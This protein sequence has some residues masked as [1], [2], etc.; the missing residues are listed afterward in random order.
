[1]RPGTSLIWTLRDS[2]IR[3]ACGRRFRRHVKRTIPHMAALRDRGNA[4]VLAILL[5][6]TFYRP[7]LVRWL[8][9]LIWMTTSLARGTRETISVGPAQL[10]LRHWR[11]AGLLDGVDFSLRRL[12]TVSSLEANYEACRRYLSARG[13]LREHDPAALA[14]TYAGGERLAFPALLAQARQVVAGQASA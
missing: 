2:N 3:L 9:Y 7:R 12:A 14:R 6:E 1:M 5:V 11:D 8:E 10:Q 4:N 13:A